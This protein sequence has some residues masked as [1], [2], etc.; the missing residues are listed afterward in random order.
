MASIT[1]EPRPAARGADRAVSAAMATVM[2][3]EV[4][5]LATRWPLFE[6]T[7]D[8]GL[9]A[10]VALSAPRFG[11]REVYL[12]TLCAALAGAVLATHDAPW[13][14][15]AGALDQAAFLMAFI[16]LIGLV[17]QAASSSGAIR[18]CGLFLT[19]Q[20]SGRRYLALFLGTHLMAQ[21]FNLGAISLLTPLVKS[22]SA[23]N[24][25]DALQPIRERRQLN[26]LL[27][28]FAWCVI[29]SPTAVAPLV[30]M[31]LLPAADRALWIGAGVAI[32]M[33]VMLVGWAEDRWAWRSV[34]RRLAQGAPSAAPPFPARAFGDFGLVCL[35]LLGL[36][37]GAMALAEGTVVFGLMAASPLVLLGW[38]LG[39]NGVAAGRASA[40]L[41]ATGVRLSEI[42]RGYLPRS[43]PLGVTLACSGFVGRA[44]AAL[45]PAA[46]WAEAAGLADLPGWVFCVGLNANWLRIATP[47]E[48]P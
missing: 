37:L 34:R 38:L 6:F 22:G 5:W 18:D 15:L 42:Y 48:S 44:A 7:V 43:A 16:L 2:A 4:L 27:R 29:W 31:T 30:V 35:A 20:P 19:R 45:I 1:E 11:L 24:A 32:A 3:S 14:V 46:D 21:I 33:V 26:A 41:R 8:A 25:E 28:G 13:A 40:A 9:I 10:V 47:T 12:L 17:Q 36:T 23:A 39:Q